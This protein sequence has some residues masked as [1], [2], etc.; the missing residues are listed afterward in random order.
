MKIGILGGSFDPPHLGHLELAQQIIAKTE[1][2][3][4]WFVPCYM[5]NFDK[6]MSSHQD[7]LTM[8]KMMEEEGVKASDIEIKRKGVSYTIETMDELKKKYPS[9]E[10]YWIMGSDQ[11]EFFPKY[12]AW[13]EILTRH[14]V[15]IFPRKNKTEKIAENIKKHAIVLDPKEFKINTVS[16]T[17]I[18][19]KVGR[20]ENISATVTK[21]VEKY[22]FHQKLYLISKS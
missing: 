11:I 19:E 13:Q 1:I 7:R 4:V 12:K 21:E 17:E 8:V 10:F 18:R 6:K 3:E 14:N 5:H 2:D 22:I 16:S 9:D 15:I 20:R